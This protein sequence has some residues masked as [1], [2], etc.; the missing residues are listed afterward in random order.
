MKKQKKFNDLMMDG[1]TKLGISQSDS[2]I[3]KHQLETKYG[4]LYLSLDGASSKVYSVLTKFVD[5]KRV[6]T[7]AIDCNLFSGKWNFHAMVKD[8]S[9]E[10]YSNIILEKIKAII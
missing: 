8:Y 7:S 1:L 6:P 2:N 5:I 3:Y 4:K 9:P 10:C